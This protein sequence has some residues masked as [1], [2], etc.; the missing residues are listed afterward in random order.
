MRSSGSRDNGE[1]RHFQGVV[2]RKHNMV[3]LYQEDMTHSSAAARSRLDRFYFNQHSMEQIDKIIQ[4]TPLEWK[5]D[6]SHHRAV[7]VSRR[8]PVTKN[9]DQRPITKEVFSHPD[10]SRRCALSLQ[11]KLKEQPL[12]SGLGKLILLKE[13]MREVGDN[14]RSSGDPPG[15]ATTDEDM[16]STT[17]KYIRA[18]E[19]HAMGTISHCLTRYPHIRNLVR[20]PYASQG[21]LSSLLADIKDHAVDL[22]RRVAPQWS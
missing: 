17:M 20:N 3:E 16:L 1:E 15:I 13:A 2:A 14:I 22:A 11:E 6:L 7:L 18:V 19:H 12:T 9:K 8:S 21:N 5:P 4:A 10:F